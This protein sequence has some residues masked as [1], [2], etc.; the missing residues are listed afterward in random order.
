MSRSFY[1]LTHTE[2]ISNGSLIKK[3]DFVIKTHIRHDR[4]VSELQRSIR[5]NLSLQSGLNLP[6]ESDITFITHKRSCYRHTTL[7][8][9]QLI[10][11]FVSQRMLHFIRY[12]CP[13]HT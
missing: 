4:N 10:A 8:T 6:A 1:K 9:F 7:P 5:L 13:H 3:T 2:V 11:E 12:P